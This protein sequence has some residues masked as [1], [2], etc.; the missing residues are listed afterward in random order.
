MTARLAVLASG[1]GSNLGAVLH[2]CDEG[3]LDA[4][5]VLVVV[6]RRD[7]GAAARA[8]RHG[9]DVVEHLLA[10]RDPDTR[11]DYDTRLAGIVADAR[12]DWVVLAGWMHILSMAFLGRFP[13]RVV[14]LH[15]ALPGEFP[16]VD[17][18]RRAWEAGRDDGLTRTGVT[19]HLVP[20]EGVDEGPV[21]ATEEVELRPGESLED[22]TER[23]HGVEHRLLVETLAGLVRV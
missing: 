9:V 13:D 15:P 14:N 4:D 8:R 3:A 6:N 1:A 2:A 10:A 18:I 7:A 11:R 5:V 12:P 23:I 22:L 17:A 20:D 16:G 21:L 19:V